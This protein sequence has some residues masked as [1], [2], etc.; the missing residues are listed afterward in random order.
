MEAAVG[1]WEVL[2]VG[3]CTEGGGSSVLLAGV[4]VREELMKP[5]FQ[6][7]S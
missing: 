3:L 7:G 5:S 4:R 2:C 1:E 6:R